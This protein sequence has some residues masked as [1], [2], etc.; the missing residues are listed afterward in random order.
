MD[1]QIYN[2]KAKLKRVVDG[3]TIV[4]G[5]DLGLRIVIDDFKIRFARINAPEMRSGGKVAKEFL[6]EY[7]EEKEI[8]V[9]TLNDKKDK[10]GRY[11]CEIFVKDG[12]EWINVNDKM[13]ETGNAK[14]YGVTRQI[15]QL[16]Y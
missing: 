5:L 3:D 4:V 6:I 1:N 15:R 10:Y 9:V 8:V 11:L 2:Y 16:K 14:W 12:E 7:L 13:V